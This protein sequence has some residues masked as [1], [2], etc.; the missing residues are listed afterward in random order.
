MKQTPGRTGGGSGDAEGGQET[1]KRAFSLWDALVFP[2]VG[3]SRTRSILLHLNISFGG[4]LC[5]TL[6]RAHHSL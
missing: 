5:S 6:L 1:R 3:G 4:A 2:E